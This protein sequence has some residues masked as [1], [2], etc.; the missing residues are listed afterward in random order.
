LDFFLKQYKQIHIS[1]GVMVKSFSIFAGLLLVPMLTFAFG[2]EKPV[3]TQDQFL[4]FFA[5]GLIE[6]KDHCPARSSLSF[7]Q[8]Q[9]LLKFGQQIMKDGSGFSNELQSRL[10]ALK[11][12]ATIKK[13]DDCPEEIA[14]RGP[15]RCYTLKFGSSKILDFA[16]GPYDGAGITCSKIQTETQPTKSKDSGS[17]SGASQF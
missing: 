7:E 9:E 11:P 17:A 5:K 15:Q 14:A 3:M 13:I 4:S 2:E 8:K 12:D 16:V 6:N 10:K 1:G